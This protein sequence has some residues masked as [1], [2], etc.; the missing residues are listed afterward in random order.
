LKIAVVQPASRE[1]ALRNTEKALEDGSQLVL[2]PE[3][4]VQTLEELPVC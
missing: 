2:L 4:W 3:K 1:S